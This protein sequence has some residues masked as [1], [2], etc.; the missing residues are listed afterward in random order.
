MN[1]R[2]S[3]KSDISGWLNINKESNISTAKVVAIVKKL[4]GAKKVGHAG[5]L[6]PMATGV[7]P[8]ALGT[9]TKT[10]RFV[11]N[12]IKQYEFEVKWG[13]ETDTDDIEGNIIKKSSKRPTSEEIIKSINKF[14]GEIVQVPPKYSA[15]KVN[16]VRSYKIARKFGNPILKS[17]KVYVKKLELLK[18]IDSDSSKFFLECEKGVYVRSIARDLAQ[19]LGTNGHVSKLCRLSVN[20]FYYKDAILLADLSKLVDKSVI[21][22]SIIPIS[23]VLDDIPAFEIDK[24]NATK[25]SNGQKIYFNNDYLEGKNKLEEIFITY[26]NNPMAIARYENGVISPKKVF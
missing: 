17:R 16:G 2:E 3:N 8:I 7:L 5:T 21:I 15:I 25:I 13:A 10:V 4:T 14:T 19:Y 9:A 26:K 18:Y 12:G 6:D 22:E 1:M 20:K 23:R 24:V 11:M